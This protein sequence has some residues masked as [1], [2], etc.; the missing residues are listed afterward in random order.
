MPIR[1][2]TIRLALAFMVALSASSCAFLGLGPWHGDATDAVR[3]SFETFDPE[4]GANL[5]KLVVSSQT[6]TPGQRSLDAVVIGEA[7]AVEPGVES[8]WD[9]TASLLTVEV[10][11]TV[12]QGRGADIGPTITV[13]VSHYGDVTLE[14]V[15]HDYQGIGEVLWLLSQHSPS[16]DD[17]AG[18]W[19]IAY[20]QALIASIHDGNELRFPLFPYS[21]GP[22]GI[23]IEALRAW[24]ERGN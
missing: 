2:T 12:V 3:D 20:N 19:S 4:E 17:D 1:I 9:L 6:R 16:Y 18:V 7:A 15:A 22:E 10:S 13:G 21:T 8:E 24:A 5:R 23:T 11:E 14:N